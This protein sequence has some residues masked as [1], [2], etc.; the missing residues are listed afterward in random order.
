MTR[1]LGRQLERDYNEF[2]SIQINLASILMDPAPELYS[3]KRCLNE[4]SRTYSELNFESATF[5]KDIEALI[6]GH[7]R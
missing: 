4:T 7:I 1:A 2:E 6:N 3:P 5:I